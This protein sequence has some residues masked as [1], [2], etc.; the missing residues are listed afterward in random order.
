MRDC[1]N[2]IVH[3]IRKDIYKKIDQ[4]YIK[5]TYDQNYICEQ[6]KCICPARARNA[7]SGLYTKFD[8]NY[9]RLN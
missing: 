8:Q 5:K 7:G 2:Y 3:A 1:V 6:I 4:T 9:M